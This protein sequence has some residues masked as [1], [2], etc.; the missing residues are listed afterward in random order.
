[1]DKQQALRFIDFLEGK[2]PIQ[3]KY[4][5][6]LLTADHK[7]NVGKFKHNYMVTICPVCKDDLTLLPRDLARNLSSI[8]QLVLIK[9]INS[10]IVVVDPFTGEV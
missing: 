7:S 6:K 10:G 5:R 1:M 9:A 4:S 8:S 3:S 2:I